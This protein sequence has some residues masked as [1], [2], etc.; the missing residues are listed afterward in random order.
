MKKQKTHKIV[1]KD[2]VV[3]HIPKQKINFWLIGIII[4]IILIIGAV[5]ATVMLTK[6]KTTKTNDHNIS[7]TTLD[8]NLTEDEFQIKVK[9][10]GEIV[11]SEVDEGYNA[12]FEP[13]YLDIGVNKTQIDSCI[14][15]IMENPAHEI[16]SK[17]QADR[18]LAQNLKI[19]GTPA[20][21]VGSYKISGAKD[22]NVFKQY[23]N[24]AKD[25]AKTNFS[26]DYT[27]KTYKS[28]TTIPAKLIII[29]NENHQHIKDGTDTLITSLQNETTLN[30]QLANF[31]EYMF[32]LPTERYSYDSTKGKEILEAI[33][34][35]Q[36]PVFYIEGKVDESVLL[37]D[38]NN[39]QI[40]NRL[41]AKT[42]A[43]GYQFNEE[44]MSEAVQIIPTDIIQILDTSLLADNRDFVMGNTSSP[45]KMYVFT[46]F[47]C[48]FCAKFE[49]ETQ[50]R[51]LETDDVAI[52]IKDFIAV[53]SHQQTAIKP[54]LVS[55]CVEKQGKYLEMHQAL[56]E[57]KKENNDVYTNIFNS[58]Y[59]KHLT[60]I[61]YLEEQYNR[62][63]PQDTN[64]IAQ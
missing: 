18:E 17:I 36:I 38:E 9:E 41:F 48:S 5:F 58:V 52:I 44:I 8:T 32:D 53:P 35:K 22:Y 62:L 2:Q 13:I 15:E 39:S 33:D 46:D 34:A 6:N 50:K 4:L 56:F 63:Y 54:L 16:I 23:I 29:D 7:I 42:N 51:I 64:Q 24:L 12:L 60:A 26:L 37:T 10:L 25:D 57:L 55:R 31:F 59:S 45:V 30:P 20:I 14:A 49:T 47:E 11:Q 27:N 61:A 43:N 28:N 3:N 40:F 19:T 21:I 1:H